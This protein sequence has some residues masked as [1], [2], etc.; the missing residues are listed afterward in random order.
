MKNF[1]DR[2]RENL[3][4]FPQL[5]AAFVMVFVALALLDYVKSLD[6][7]SG[8]EVSENSGDIGNMST[9]QAAETIAS[10]LNSRTPIHR[11]P[12]T[13]IVSAKVEGNTVVM[14]VNIRFSEVE[15]QELRETPGYE[16]DKFE[17]DFAN[18]FMEGF[19]SNSGSLE[20]YPDSVTL[21]ADVNMGSVYRFRT[22][23]VGT[24]NCGV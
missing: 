5:L 17:K 8:E 22:E 15:R 23:P 7:F 14:Y 3:L 19:C 12:D 9:K 6:L 2:F 21:Q 11:A 1:I 13:R 4:P 18:N 16:I 10:N 20:K 24:S